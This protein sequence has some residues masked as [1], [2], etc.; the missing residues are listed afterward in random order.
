MSFAKLIT[1]MP[2]VFVLVLVIRAGVSDVRRAD[3]G[4]APRDLQKNSDRLLALQTSIRSVIKKSVPCVVSVNSGTGVIVSPDGL[5]LSQAHITHGNEVLNMQGAN[6]E[7]RERRG[8]A[9]VRLPDGTEEIADVLGH[10]ALCDV[11]VAKLRRPGPYPF[12]RLADKPAEPGSWLVKCG[13]PTPL[14][15]KNGRPPEARIGKVLYR[16]DTTLVTD[17]LENGGDS[18]GPYF[19]LDGNVV[20]ISRK[21][22]MMV[23]LPYP[24]RMFMMKIGNLWSAATPTTVIRGRLDAMA[25]GATI[26]P[27]PA[28]RTKF[29]TT[30]EPRSADLL[31]EDQWTEGT[32][33]LELFR[34]ANTGVNASV[35]EILAG[36][37]RAALGTVVDADG[38]VLT[39]ASEVPDRP[40]CRLGDGRVLAAQVV[41]ADPAYDLALLRVPATRLPTDYLGWLKRFDA[42]HPS[43][44]RWPWCIAY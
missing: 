1:R 2:P 36:D 4:S 19:D 26:E 22:F 12:A 21:S 40:Q 24:Q 39:K 16:S 35:V 44:C 14:R 15:H 28:E 38:L 23:D 41:G 10:D 31:S 27:T 3:A 37:I 17:C 30:S 34:Q 11:S 33:S 8:T 20:G 6:K 13:Y 43:S 42:G 5:I 29:T 32:K 18:G 7:S 9:K 25:R